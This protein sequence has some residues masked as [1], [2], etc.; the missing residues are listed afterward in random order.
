MKTAVLA[1]ILASSATAVTVDFTPADVLKQHREIH[2]KRFF[3]NLKSNFLAA[4]E[5]GTLQLRKDRK[6]YSNPAYLNLQY[7]SD[8]TCEAKPWASGGWGSGT[9]V[10]LGT[11]GGASS[12]K[13]LGCGGAGTNIT[14]DFEQYDSTED[15]SGDPSDE[16]TMTPANGV[17]SSVLNDGPDDDNF[18]IDDRF[19]MWYDDDPSYGFAYGQTYQILTCDTE[20]NKPSGMWASTYEDSTCDALQ[21]YFGFNEGGCVPYNEAVSPLPLTYYVVLGCKTSVRCN[22]P[23][24]IIL[25]V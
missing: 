14:I 9:C 23:F 18:N 6:L 21:G 4:R 5:A 22:C 20:I 2:Q 13:I 11:N 19:Q 25:Y 1:S 7:Y 8:D 16:G 17:C 15:C 10:P 12:F 24:V 3:S